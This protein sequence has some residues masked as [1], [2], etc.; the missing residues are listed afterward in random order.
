MNTNPVGLF[1][2]FLHVTGIL[3]IHGC[4]RPECVVRINILVQNCWASISKHYLWLHCDDPINWPKQHLTSWDTKT[5]WCNFPTSFSNFLLDTPC[6]I[7][8]TVFGSCRAVFCFF[9]YSSMHYVAPSIIHPSIS[10]RTSH[11]SSPS[12]NFLIMNIGSWLDH[13]SLW[14]LAAR[15]HCGSDEEVSAEMI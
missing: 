12:I 13:C 8:Y 6:F 2:E 5:P 4:L 1:L 9:P 7:L 10:F 15:I 3:V 14:L 11:S